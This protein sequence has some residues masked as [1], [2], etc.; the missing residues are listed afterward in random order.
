YR[1]V[2]GGFRR[3]P[4]PAGRAGDR[5]HHRRHLAGGEL[6]RGRR[7]H[8]D[9]PAAA[10]EVRSVSHQEPALPP[11]AVVP[12]GPSR[13]NPLLVTGGVIVVII[14]IVA[15]V[16]FVW[17]PLPTLFTDTD[18]LAVGPGVGGHLLG[19]DLRGR[20]IASWLMAGSRTTLYVGIVA[21][22]IAAVVGTPLGIVA[23]M[24]RPA[25]SEFVMRI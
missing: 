14:T 23:G 15:I 7:L 10:A 3:P 24:V 5:R 9:R 22:G 1:V 20:D 12:G 13:W 19:T 2:P 17:T 11:A 25:A 4:G 6:R 16:S 21:V 8:D 18:H